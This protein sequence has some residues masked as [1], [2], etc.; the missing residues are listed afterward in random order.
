MS[1]GAARCWINSV[2]R[3]LRQ[4][5]V[6]SIRSLIF[7]FLLNNNCVLFLSDGHYH[8]RIVLRSLKKEASSATA[9]MVLSGLVASW[10][11]ISD[12]H[13]FMAVYP[14]PRAY[15]PAP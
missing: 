14:N 12:G 3:R 6:R 2:P 9:V 1:D 10:H 13:I 5:L 4:S 15:H 7:P 8:H 11:T